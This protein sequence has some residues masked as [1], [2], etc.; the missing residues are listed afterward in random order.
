MLKAMVK[1]LV[2]QDQLLK[3]NVERLDR[4]G[5]SSARTTWLITLELLTRREGGSGKRGRGGADLA[6]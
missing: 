6:G 5:Y 3:L 2:V 1:I 4:I